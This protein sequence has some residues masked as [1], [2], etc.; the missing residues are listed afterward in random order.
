MAR[1]EDAFA[2]MSEPPPKGGSSLD[3]GY[4]ILLGMEGLNTYL[5]ERRA[6]IVL[7]LLLAIQRR[8]FMARRRRPPRPWVSLSARVWK[9]AGNPSKTRRVA[10]LAQLRRMSD[11][12]VLQGSHHFTSRY[13]VGKG[14]AWLEI[15]KGSGVKR[16]P[17]EEDEEKD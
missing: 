3:N 10:I 16:A 13:C 7:P 12:V 8:L 14:P 15:E 11:L 4:V 9:E 6:E 17:A 1:I 2:D 5:V